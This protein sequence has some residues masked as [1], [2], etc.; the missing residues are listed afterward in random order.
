MSDNTLFIQLGHLN[1][2]DLIFAEITGIPNLSQYQF[3]HAD[4]IIGLGYN[5]N[6]RTTNNTFFYKLLD[7]KKIVNPIFS[8]YM[9]R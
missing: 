8:V 6:A 3:M 4:G 7:D 2:T 9:N 1:V 5:T